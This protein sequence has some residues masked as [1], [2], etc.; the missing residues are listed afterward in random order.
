V[1]AELLSLPALGDEVYAL[2]EEVKR[3]EARLEELKLRVRLTEVEAEAAR[4][5][6]QFRHASFARDHWRHVG[7]AMLGFPLGLGLGVL[8]AGLVGVFPLGIGGALLAAGLM[9]ALGGRS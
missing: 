9:G 6:A 7:A 3:A 5:P 1:A 8:V 2:E 4:D